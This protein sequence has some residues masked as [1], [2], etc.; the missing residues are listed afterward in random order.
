MLQY[1]LA[2]HSLME[3]KN[4]MSEELSG[5]CKCKTLHKP[6]EILNGL[7]CNQSEDRVDV[8]YSESFLKGMIKH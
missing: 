4:I 5:K 8:K 2:P 6:W 7:K 3:H 1:N